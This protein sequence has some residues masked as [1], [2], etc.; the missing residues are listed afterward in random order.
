MIYNEFINLE[1]LDDLGDGHLRCTR[2]FSRV[3]RSKA[4][5]CVLMRENRRNFFSVCPL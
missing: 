4:V 1:V 2:L 5:L 3:L